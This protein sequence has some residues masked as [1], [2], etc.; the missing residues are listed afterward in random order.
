[1]D[2][3]MYAAV[4]GSLAAQQRLDAIANNLANASTPGFKAELLIQRS[5]EVGGRSGTVGAT[6]T[7]ITRGDLQTNFANGPVEHTGNPLDIALSGPGF[8]VVDG[9]RGERL[10]RRGTLAI[11]GDGILTTSDG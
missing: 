9:P 5:D 1:M 7:P 4:S 2:A 3:G 8:L 11:D 6:P 10:T